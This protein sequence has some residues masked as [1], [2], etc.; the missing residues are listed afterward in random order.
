MAQGKIYV[1]I[2]PIQIT[3]YVFDFGSFREPLTQAFFDQDATALEKIINQMIKELRHHPQR[4]FQ[5]MDAAG[6][7]LYLCISQF[8]A[9]TQL[10]LWGREG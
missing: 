6:N 8:P 9:L 10:E 5:A 7:L 1:K 4:Q 3:G 2:P